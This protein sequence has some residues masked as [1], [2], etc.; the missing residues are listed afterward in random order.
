MMIY[1]ENHSF[2]YEVENI[3]NLFFP[4]EKNTVTAVKKMPSLD[5]DCILTYRR[6]EIQGECVGAVVC[7]G[8]FRKGK[9]LR[10][11]PDCADYEHEAE[12]KLAVCMYRLLEECTNHKQPW[13][14]LTGVRPIKLMRRL[15]N[16]EGIEQAKRYFQKSL[17]VSEEKTN[18]SVIT[19]QNE[20]KILSLSR[21]DSFSLYVSIPFCPSRCSYCSFVSQSIEKAQKLIEPYVN[22]LCEEI[23]HTAQIA[24]DCHLRL[25]T[26]YI[27][28]GTPTTLN[29][30]QLKQLIEAIQSSFDLSTC[31]EFTIEAGR[32]DTIDADKLNVMYE[33]G[34]DRISINPQTLNNAVLQVIGRHHTAEQTLEAYALAEKIGFRHINMDLIAGLPTDT[35]ESFAD[36]L[37]RICTLSPASITVHTLAKKR[38]SG[39]SM[40]GEAVD[41]GSVA[42]DMLRLCE[43]KLTAEGYHPYYLYRQSRMAGNLENV[44]W[45]KEGFDG[46][47]NVYV[48][49]ETH[50]ILGCGAGAVTKLK[51]PYNET[52]TRIFNYKYPYEYINGFDEMLKRKAQVK[53]FYDEL[54]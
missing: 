54:S 23:R 21:P 44:G 37:N 42:A 29:P 39:L 53:T 7:I 49:D 8:G 10:L 47:Y 18:L 27:G 51:N 50:T 16:A 2:A 6:M 26:V 12:R 34:I 19:E 13:G 17:L 43:Q 15:K 38:S 45:A 28:G 24:K 52:L 1:A 35:Y 25:E 31:R 40:Q 3:A 22:L 41:T 5:T 30:V 32:P 14:I 9:S 33:H 48:M 11:I 4:N 20:Q 46:L 36:T